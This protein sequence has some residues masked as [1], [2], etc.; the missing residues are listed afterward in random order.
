MSAHGPGE[1]IQVVLNK[2]FQFGCG[3]M[4]FLIEQRHYKSRHLPN[5]L[6]GTSGSW[7]TAEPEILLVFGLVEVG[8]LLEYIPKSSSDS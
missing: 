6:S 4:N 8:G 5:K 2:V 7:V 3:F 1:W